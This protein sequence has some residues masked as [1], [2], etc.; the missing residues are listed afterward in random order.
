MGRKFSK[1]LSLNL[2][3]EF[4]IA[5]QREV[6]LEMQKLTLIEMET[7]SLSGS[8]LP[9]IPAGTALSVSGGHSGVH[10][11]GFHLKPCGSH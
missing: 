4:Q 9:K 5:E 11:P 7:G 1:V 10:S 8:D 2:K 6:K 3:K